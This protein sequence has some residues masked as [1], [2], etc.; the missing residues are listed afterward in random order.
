MSEVATRT[1]VE[2]DRGPDRIETPV[3]LGNAR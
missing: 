1:A 3:R 2:S